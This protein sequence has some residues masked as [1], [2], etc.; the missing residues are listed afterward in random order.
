M[1]EEN[2]YQTITLKEEENKKQIVY[3][4]IKSI[5]KHFKSV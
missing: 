5:R 4:N 1:T 2:I 3:A